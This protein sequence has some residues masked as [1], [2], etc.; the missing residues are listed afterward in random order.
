V[1]QP[2]SWRLFFEFFGWRLIPLRR[3]GSELLP[4]FSSSENCIASGGQRKKKGFGYLVAVFI[5]MLP[6][7]LSR[8]GVAEK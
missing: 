4:F 2:R 8:L 7:I 1:N 5:K 6:V 3:L